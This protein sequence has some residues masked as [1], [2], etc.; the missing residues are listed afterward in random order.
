[1]GDLADRHSQLRR[2]GE[3]LVTEASS[4]TV[5]THAASSNDHSETCPI[6]GPNSDA[7]QAAC[8]S[9]IPQTT[10]ASR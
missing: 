2:I 7:Q 8:H 4:R 6:T 3:I 1:M 10:V 9:P 5:S